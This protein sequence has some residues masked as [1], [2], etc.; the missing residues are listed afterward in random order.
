[1]LMNL[2]GATSEPRPMR[3]TL[4]ALLASVVLLVTACSPAPSATPG[5]TTPGGTA[6]PGATTVPTTAARVDT[7]TV[8]V[9]NLGSQI[10]APWLSGQEN[11]IVVG[12]IGDTLTEINKQTN[13]VEPGLA[14]SW[15]IS[16]DLKTWTIKMRGDVPF[17]GGYGNVTADDVKFSFEQW[18]NEESVHGVIGEQVLRSIDG[19]IANFEIVSP[20][21]F[22]LHTE[23]PVVSLPHILS[24]AAQSITIQSK[25]Y[26]EAEPVQALVK[27]LGSGPY[28]FVSNTPG[29]EV[30]LKAIASHPFRGVP[31]SDNLIIKEIPDSAARLA[32]VQ[33]GG[34]DVA[35]LDPGL[36]G[37]ATAASLSIVTT[38]DVESCGITL[39]GYYPGTTA[40]DSDAPWVQS[41]D[42]AKGKA[43]REAMSLAI[44]RVTILDRL[45]A[46]YGVLT[47]G[48][49]LNYPNNPALHDSAWAPPPFDVALAKQ[50]L[51]EGGFPNGF[52]IT[53]R[54][55]EQVPAGEAITDMW[56]EIG[57]DVTLEMTEQALMRPLFQ[58]SNQPEGNSDTD[59]L[60]WIFC[61]SRQ[62]SPEM[63]LPNAWMKTGRNMQA[64]NPAIDVA[65]E[66]MNA[67]GDE[68]ARFKLARD[69]VTTLR[70]DVHPINLYTV[71]YPFVL[72][73]RV[74]TW[75]PV[76]GL[77][78]FAAAETIAL[79]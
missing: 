49:V 79:K 6:G 65:Y 66:A 9:D 11:R 3:R 25:K 27:P 63:A 64:F 71:D 23:S 69:L 55:W 39:G 73:S 42:P 74:A 12:L 18:L 59:G 75:A 37:E 13:E 7:L 77:N 32:Q 78:A 36:A 14:E 60:A 67:E 45:I 34:I 68:A 61:S 43:I 58:A 28:E 22:R 46:G 53:L 41:S 31:A 20:T 62:P 50:K 21:E 2:A 35:L 5:S 76:P 10:Y 54:L 29:V 16:D 44:D 38:K 48:P 1:M 33:S 15:T 47:Y 56:K 70:E 52:P 8:A 30:V 4:A 72:G 57:I 51:A 19:D 24:D 17:Q 40:L 26:F